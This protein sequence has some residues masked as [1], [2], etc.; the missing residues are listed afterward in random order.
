MKTV[1]EVILST[2]DY[3]RKHGLEQPRLNIEHLLAHVLGQ[4][5]IELYLGFDRILSDE[6]LSPLRELV[7]RR[8]LGE[9]LQHL[10]GT[11][12]FLGRTFKADQRALI[13]RPETEQFVEEILA[14][15]RAF[16][17][18]LDVGTGSGVIALTL[19]AELPQ[20]AVEACDLSLTALDLARENANGLG[21]GKRVDFIESDLLENT[22][23]HYDLIAANLP[24]I[25]S[26]A[27][28]TL[29]REV[30]HDPRLALDGGLGG[31]E[32]LV[33]LIPA[34]TEHLGGMLALEIGH[35]QAERVTEELVRHKYRD[36]RVKRDYQGRNR[37][38][39]ANYG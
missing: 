12:E 16:R 6:E 39:F 30:Q 5:R 34:A 28:N 1:L 11:V 35:D 26:I 21:L 4:R 19:A 31:L 23:G 7:R 22:A 29:S 17:R 37:F 25:D 14:Q 15:G 24:Y 8:A 18:I 20:A 2:A 10:L 27:V 33:R 3:F 9:P 36:I 32:L 13:P 38:V